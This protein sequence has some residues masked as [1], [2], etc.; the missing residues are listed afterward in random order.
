VGHGDATLIEWFP[1]EP[2]NRAPFRCLVDGG[3]SPERLDA[4]LE[5]RSASKIDLLV[6]SHFDTDH[7]GGLRDIAEKRPVDTYWGPCLPAFERHL[8]LFGDRIRDGIEKAAALQESLTRAGAD[9]LYPLEGFVSAQYGQAGPALRILS[10]AARMI[11][12]LLVRE[13]IEWLV[14]QTPTPLGWLV[15][16]EDPPVEQPA[17]VEALD[18]QLLSGALSPGDLRWVSRIS[19]RNDD[20]RRN[21]WGKGLGVAPEFFGD[22]LLNNTS[23]VL[24]VEA[25]GPSGRYRLLLT[26]DQENWTYLLLKHPFGLLAD[27]LKAPHHGGSLYIENGASHE[28]ILSAVRP[29]VVVFSAN[30]RYGLP[31]AEIRES[32]IRWGA[33]VCCTSMRGVELIAGAPNGQDSCCHAANRCDGSRNVSLTLDQ[34]GI[35]ADSPACHSGFGT[36][37]GPIIQIRQHVIDGNPVVQHLFE[38][39]LR[40]S[41][42]WIRERLR[43]LHRQR[44]SAT[45]ELTTGSEF[46]KL[47]ELAALARAAGRD[48]L[49][50]NLPTV[51]LQGWERNRFWCARRYRSEADGAYTLPTEAEIEQYLQALRNKVLLLFIFEDYGQHPN[52]A[53]KSTTV[54]NLDRGVLAAFLDALLHF[55]AGMFEETVW[56]HVARELLTSWHCYRHREGAIGLS[57]FGSAKELCIQLMRECYE[58]TTYHGYYGKSLD[59]PLYRLKHR[60]DPGLGWPVLVTSHPKNRKSWNQYWFYTTGE[61]TEVPLDG[62]TQAAD[63]LAAVLELVW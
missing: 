10:P 51:L 42:A 23:L 56:P 48:L 24:W 3:E 2:Q 46:I 28:E 19:A 14:T 59:T 58:E 7:I 41:I 11:R 55:P 29:R 16:P 18:A 12:T 25:A 50:H 26:G 8:W 54:L 47:D 61:L 57:R 31:H 60:S 39:E 30:G 1:D 21:A 40:K 22:S 52:V 5:A 20:Q 43:E 4:A 37:P 38:Q 62:L 6:V 36:A 15:E 53:D 35:A 33:T 9:V 49:A 34:T 13:D 32:A 63:S 44:S 45:Q 27:I 17:D